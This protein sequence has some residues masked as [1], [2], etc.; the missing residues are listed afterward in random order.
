MPILFPTVL[1]QGSPGENLSPANLVDPDKILAFIMA[2]GGGILLLVTWTIFRAMKMS[3]RSRELQHVERVKAIE[4]GQPWQDPVEPPEPSLGNRFWICFWI[5]LFGA[6]I[7]FS[8]VPSSLAHMKDV[9]DSVTLAAYI[10]AGLAA[11]TASV[12]SAIIMCYTPNNSSS[13]NC[14]D[15]R[16]EQAQSGK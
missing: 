7:P 4:C 1:A 16:G 3:E 11:A 2:G 15:V 14:N 10:S 13:N 8:S 12:C 5:M 6:G 9:S